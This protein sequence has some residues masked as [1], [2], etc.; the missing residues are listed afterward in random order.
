MNTRLAVALLLLF[1]LTL[2]AVP[3]WADS[4]TATGSFLP[5]NPNAS[6]TKL[7]GPLTIL[8]D[9]ATTGSCAAFDFPVNM[10]FIVRL[11]I[12]SNVWAFS[13][14]K[15]STPT[16]A[17]C[18]SDVP[19]QIQVITDFFNS[20][21]MAGLKSVGAVSPTAPAP[22]LKSVTDMAT[23]NQPQPPP[24]LFTVLDVVL[25]VRE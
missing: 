25:A 22:E 2:P 1:G 20:T 10:F 12:G 9:P 21:V 18:F 17:I 13:G 11:K 6:G 5:I 24:L 19:K 16:V 8:F 3:A 15:G 4:Q 23:Q 14:A 7:S